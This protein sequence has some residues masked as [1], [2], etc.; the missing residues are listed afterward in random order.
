MVDP[1][2]S[3]ALSHIDLFPKEINTSSYY[4]LLKI[5]GIGVKSAKKIISSRKHFKI[6]F[7]DL[8]NMGVVMKR[9]KYFITCNGKYFI[10]KDLL[11]KEF[12]E[13]NLVLEDKEIIKPNITQLSL[14][15]E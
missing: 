15:N 13:S 6:E 8:K 10:N 11:K 7:K 14:F 9:A 5:P 3:W 2:A 1:K 4:D 12:I